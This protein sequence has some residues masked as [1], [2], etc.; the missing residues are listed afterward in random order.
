MGVYEARG[1]LSKSIKQLEN[2]WTETRTTWD[3]PR[4]REFEERFIVQ[5]RADLQ[6]AATAM[7]HIAVLLSRIHSECE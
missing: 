7:D 5:I 6:M 3:D 2:R 1:M 4:T